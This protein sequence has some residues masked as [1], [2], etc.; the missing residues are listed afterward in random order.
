MS[1]FI[2]LIDPKDRDKDFVDSLPGF[3]YAIGEEWMTRD[4]RGYWVQVRCT[5]D[6]SMHDHLSEALTS[7]RSCHDEA[8][9]MV[10]MAYRD[11]I[12][13]TNIEVEKILNG[14][15]RKL[16]ES[17]LLP[18]VSGQKKAGATPQK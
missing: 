7:E 6:L 10:G 2:N 13:K 4:H 5:E 3:I 15:K 9:F 16:R 1:D 12:P 17:G 11:L 8:G 18:I 14:I